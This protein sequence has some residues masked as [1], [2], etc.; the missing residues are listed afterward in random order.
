MTAI[1]RGNFYAIAHSMIITCN[2]DHSVP[3]NSLVLAT[4]SGDR[5]TALDMIKRANTQPALLSALK[6]A[7][8]HLEDAVGEDNELVMELWAAIDKATI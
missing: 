2:E 8:D 1:P 7:H 5:D 3:L 6:S 4:V